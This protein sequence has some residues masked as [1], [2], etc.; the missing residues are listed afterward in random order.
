M[1]HHRPKTY[2][3]SVHTA[4]MYYASYYTIKT[5]VFL[6]SYGLDSGFYAHRGD[7]TNLHK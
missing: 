1:S 4:S 7:V 3:M 6:N 5:S 2:S